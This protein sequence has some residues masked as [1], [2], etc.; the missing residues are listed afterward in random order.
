MYVNVT[1]HI[2]EDCPTVKYGSSIMG[3]FMA[4]F[5]RDFHMYTICTALLSNAEVCLFIDG[6]LQEHDYIRD[7]TN[8]TVF[9]FDYGKGVVA[10]KLMIVKREF[11]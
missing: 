2:E 3:R 11:T 5:H 1:K 6:D 10:D 9:T 4:L 8:K 7:A